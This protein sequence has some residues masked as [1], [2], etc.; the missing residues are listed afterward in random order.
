MSTVRIGKTT[1]HP[2][3]LIASILDQLG[4]ESNDRRGRAIIARLNRTYS[5]IIIDGVEFILLPSS[6]SPHNITEAA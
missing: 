1:T 3:E 4:A 5:H 2:D 6:Q